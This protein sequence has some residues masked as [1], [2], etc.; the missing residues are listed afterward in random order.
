MYAIDSYLLD[1]G[2]SMAELNIDNLPNIEQEAGQTQQA[3][4]KQPQR[5]EHQAVNATKS[6][7]V[8]TRS[9]MKPAAAYASIQP[10]TCVAGARV[11]VANGKAIKKVKPAPRRRRRRTGAFT[12]KGYKRQFANHN[13]HDRSDMSPEDMAADKEVCHHPKSGVQKVFPSLLHAMLDDADSR[14]HADIISWQPH[15]RAF[16][17]HDPT[18]FAQEILPHYFHHQKIN[19]F[20][21]QLSLYG[22]TR[23]TRS[24]MDHGAY[25]HE[26]FLRQRIFLCAKLQRKRVKGTWVRKSASPESE[27]DFYAMAPVKDLVVMDEDRAP[28]PQEEVHPGSSDVDSGADSGARC[29]HIVSEM[30]MAPSRG[31]MI[32]STAGHEQGQVWWSGLSRNS[33]SYSYSNSI[34]NRAP[35][36]APG[37]V[38]TSSDAIASHDQ[39][40]RVVI[41]GVS[42]PPIDVELDMD[43]DFGLCDGLF[44]SDPENMYFGCE[45]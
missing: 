1:N 14:G 35:A 21:R 23:L 29:N 33:N 12:R 25:Y 44:D 2:Q 36:L 27:P 42:D 15:G 3:S 4:A 11:P 41:Q 40:A 6:T 28:Q 37:W 39:P 9:N 17:I 18:R 13:Y 45:L 7:T 38:D 32:G 8:L 26:Y 16:R 34:S 10:S 24:G 30:R 5:E 31:K 19:S 20:Q 43:L 22:F